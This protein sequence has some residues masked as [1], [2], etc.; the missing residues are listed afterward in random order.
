VFSAPRVI[1]PYRPY[2]YPARTRLSI[3]VYAGYP[4]G[5]PYGYSS[6]GYGYPGYAYPGYANPGYAYAAYGGVRIQGAPRNAQVFAD[7]YYAGVVDDFDGVFQRLDLPAGPHR[8]E[9]RAPG[10]PERSVDVRVEPGR[11]ITFHADG[12]P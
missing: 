5:Y 6:Y 4:Y 3:G 7:G 10:F 9:I 1:V 8:I 12:R 2:Y 11:T